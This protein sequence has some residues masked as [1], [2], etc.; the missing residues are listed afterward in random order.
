MDSGAFGLGDNVDLV[1]GIGDVRN[2]GVVV[3]E[4]CGLGGAH[5]VLVS[6]R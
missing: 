2:R 6:S 3:S 4:T 1:C 5:K